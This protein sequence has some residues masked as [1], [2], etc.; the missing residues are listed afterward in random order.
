[1]FKHFD[2]TGVRLL[3]QDWVKDDYWRYIRTNTPTTKSGSHFAYVGDFLVDHGP[4]VD[5]WG[6]GQGNVYLG[7]AFWVVPNRSR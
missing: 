4:G 5:D 7:D 2:E 1:M 3:G 6:R